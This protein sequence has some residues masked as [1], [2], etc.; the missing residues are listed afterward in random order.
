MSQ[1]ILVPFAGEGAGVGELSW[2]QREIWEAMQRQRGWLPIGFTRPLPAGTSVE[3]VVSDLRFALRRYPSMRTR[4][5]FAEDGRPQ[6]V[7]AATGAVELEVVHAD[8]ADP[9]QLSAALHQ[10][11]MRGDHDHA[12]DWPVRMAVVCSAGVPTHQAMVACHLVSDGLGALVMLRAWARRAE[13]ESSPATALDPL[14]QAQWQQGPAGRRQSD[15][16][17]RYWAALLHT[18]RPRRFK[19]TG[20]G[21][22]PRHWRLDYHSPAMSVATRAI[23]VRNRLDSSY[24]HLAAYC[25]AL[26]RVTGVNPVV[27]QIVVG[28]R[29]RPGLADTVSPINQTGLCVI[30]VAG[31]TFDEVLAHAWRKAMGTYKHAYYDPIQLNELIERISRE[32][33]EEVD[34]GCFFNPRRFLLAEPPPGPPATPGELRAALAGSELHWGE[35]SELPVE[36]FFATLDDL[37]D[38]VHIELSV[39]TRYVPPAAMEAF[40]RGME[41]VLVEAAFDA[42]APTGVRRAPAHV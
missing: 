34:I 2:G 36:R 29:F 1:R 23:A 16:A 20:D 35:P 27:V 31:A 37:A 26:A 11:Y 33:G 17:M 25:V 10:R 30:D 21:Q 28:N 22:S 9:A 39:D 14:A 12:A 4:L 6:Q 15:N 40:V 8:G 19:S 41:A 18:I 3:D 24:V 32:R 5:R 13:L 7:V 38:S 42:D